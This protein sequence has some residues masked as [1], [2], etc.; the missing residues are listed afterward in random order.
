ML[1][2]ND[3]IFII[4]IIL[5]AIVGYQLRFLTRSG[6]VGAMIV[7]VLIYIGFQWKGLLLLALFFLTSSFWSI[8]KKDKKT[9]VDDKLEKGSRRDIQ[10]V[11][12]NGGVAAICSFLYYWTKDP[13][14]I[15]L[16]A[17]ALASPNSDTWASEI[18]TLNKQA[19][20]SI[21]TWKRVPKGTSGAISPL[22]TLAAF[23]GSHVIAVFAATLFDLPTPLLVWILVFGFIGNIIDTVLGAYF[24]A[25]YRCPV[26]HLETEKTVHCHQETK[27]IQGAAA[28]DNDAV[29]FLSCLLAVFLSHIC[30]F[31]FIVT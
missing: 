18:G 11:I 13:N 14:F 19:P 28:L 4:G 15:I 23:L 17:V 26:C 21:K 9:E 24:Q 10:Q 3:A 7:G 5:A 8:F 20:I 29:N 25:L 27:L 30:L 6:S 12:A 31:L 22:G 16:F 2:S 1:L